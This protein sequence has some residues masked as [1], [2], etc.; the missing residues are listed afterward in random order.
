MQKA[1]VSSFLYCI[2]RRPDHS[3]DFATSSSGSS[4]VRG[5]AGRGGRKRIDDP[6]I[7]LEALIQNCMWDTVML[8]LESQPMAADA[9]LAV[10][11]RGGF[12]ASSGFTPLHYACERKPP[13][14]VVHALIERAP[15]SVT[16]RT[17]PGGCL[18]LHVACTWYASSDVVAALVSA[19]QNSCRVSD[20]LG[21]IALHSA[22]FSGADVSV[23]EVLLATDGDSVLG[24]NYQGSRAADICKRLRHDNRRMVM[25]LLTLTKEEIM[26]RNRRKHSSG[27]LSETA[28]EAAEL[29][30]RLGT[31]RS[32]SHEDSDHLHHHHDTDSNGAI[33]VSYE[34][35][36]EELLWI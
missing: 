27:T 15:A 25:A 5:G 3:F 33:E 31:P 20:E 34:K 1:H 32:S 22:C 36:Q 12:M 29:N 17:L 2:L 4:S 14:E 24:R 9:E 21:N 16:T 6:K 30:E 26:A 13:A 18:P 11:T 35:G 10:M 7:P 28:R 8:R 23:V 19:D